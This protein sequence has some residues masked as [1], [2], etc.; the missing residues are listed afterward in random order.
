M[1][2]KECLM[3]H[4]D[5]T[6][7]WQQFPY[8]RVGQK[9]LLRAMRASYGVNAPRYIAYKQHLDDRYTDHAAH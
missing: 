1:I 9:Q 8:H 5:P 3:T 2:W 6:R 7:R 4:I